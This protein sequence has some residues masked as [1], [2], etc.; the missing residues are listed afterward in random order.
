M[1]AT[2]SVPKAAPI[3]AVII[4]A[5]NE[6]AVIGRTLDGLGIL[7][8]SGVIEVLVVC[9]GCTDATAEVARRYP[10]V[11]VLE[12]DAASKPAAM[13]A[14]DLAAASWPRLYL[15]ADIKIESAA[16]EAVFRTLSAAGGPLAARPESVIDSSDSSFLVRSYYRARMR[17]PDSGVR[18]WGAGAYA[19]SEAGHRRFAAF[20]EV[21]AD[22]SYFDALFTDDE[23][24]IVP[25]V[26]ML[27]RAP[28]S[29]STLLHILA[30]HRRGYLEL[31]LHADP[32]WCNQTDRTG[33]GREQTSRRVRALLAAVR[34]PR[35]GF[36]ACCYA[37]ITAL[38]RLR[39]RGRVGLGT[40]TWETDGSTRPADH[41]A[42][43]VG[44]APSSATP[45]G[46]ARAA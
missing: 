24:M 27:V 7:A 10:G 23:K 13:N 18:L 29:M 31:Q 15:D 3:G 45:A 17:I 11:T 46:E 14:G 42:T 25:T 1:T 37:A 16:V 6:E 33:A 8:R 34:D 44:A 41:A 30:R 19:V 39:T 40:R 28:R 22:D 32:K 12:A 35:S 26:P 5:H 4:P 38:A 43:P 20:P 9:N 21:T 2:S 36:D